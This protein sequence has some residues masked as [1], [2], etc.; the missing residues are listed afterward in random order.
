MKGSRRMIYISIAA[1][2]AVIALIGIGYMYLVTAQVVRPGD[3]IDIQYTGTL[4][5]GTVFSSN[6]GQQPFQFTVGAGQV[7]PGLD[8]GVVGMKLKQTKTLVIPYNEAYGPVDPSLV[9]SAPL[10]AFGNQTVKIGM[11][12]ST[13]MNGQQLSGIVTSVNATNATV[14]F[15]APL[16]GKTLIFNV[17]ILSIHPGNSTA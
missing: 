11:G 6:V 7:I 9:V 1:A 14:N 12:I 5:N 17:T 8:S 2:I 15:N 16:A 4:T 3:T 10:K 13:I